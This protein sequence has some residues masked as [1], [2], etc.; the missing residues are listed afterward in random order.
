[1]GRVDDRHQRWT[2]GVR[3]RACT[4]GLLLDILV[5]EIRL[6]GEICTSPKYFFKIDISLLHR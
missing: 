3:H 6:N 1:M 5:F 4:R 2:P